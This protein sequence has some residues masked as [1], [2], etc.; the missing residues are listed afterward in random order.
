[1]NL[2]SPKRISTEPPQICNCGND[3]TSFCLSCKIFSC[4]QCIKSQHLKH[5]NIF[6]DMNK[7]EEGVKV[8]SILIQSEITSTLNE[9]KNVEKQYEQ[10]KF[11]DLESRKEMLTRKLDEI[12]KIYTAGAK[13]IELSM[14][15]ESI[16]KKWNKIIK[17]IDRI[18]HDVS[19]KKRSTNLDKT[20]ESLS[21]MYES[22]KK[23]E[24]LKNDLNKFK[25]SYSYHK[26]IDD[27]YNLI[28]R[29]VDLILS[30]FNDKEKDGI[31]NSDICETKEIEEGRLINKK[32]KFKINSSKMIFKDSINLTNQTLELKN[33]SI[34]KIKHINY[35]K[36]VNSITSEL[37]SPIINTLRKKSVTTLL[38]NNDVFPL[39]TKPSYFSSSQEKKKIVIKKEKFLSV[40][41]PSTK[42]L[43]YN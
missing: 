24:G 7:I 11:V 1:M 10:E 31:K 25:D 3:V 13:K 41:T 34:K 39:L 8:Y 16:E 29:N 43:F 21:L 17:D 5:K 26:K 18:I 6:L 4:P 36:D 32:N 12:E 15:I 19:V 9:L 14:N 2:F 28:E 20:K 33:L 42:S 30:E 38:G 27:M 22:E 40:F 35:N 23:I 37:N